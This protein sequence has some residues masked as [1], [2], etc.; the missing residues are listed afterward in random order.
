MKQKKI[1]IV[2][3][4]TALR[5]VLAKKFKIEG[6]QAITASNGQIGLNKALK[7]HPDL[8]LLD[9]LLP[10][11]DGAELIEELQKDDWGRKATILLLT[12]VSDPVKMAQLTS[13]GKSNIGVFDYMIK[14][15]WNL[16]EIV[17]KV[18]TKLEMA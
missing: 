14:S 12:N 16:K 4:E 1:L 5:K 9:I 11:M 15:D 13:Q 10:K 8:I 2:E 6:F 3:D 18:R 17:D 7:E